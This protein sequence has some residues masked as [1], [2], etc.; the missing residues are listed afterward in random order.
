MAL[1]SNMIFK[2]GDFI[3][4]FPQF[5]IANQQYQSM[6]CSKFEIESWIFTLMAL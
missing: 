6:I 2:L 3:T 5:I 4:Y 1:P